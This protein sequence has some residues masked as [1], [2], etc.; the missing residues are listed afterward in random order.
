[1]KRRCRAILLLLIISVAGVNSLPAET[2]PGRPSPG[3]RPAGQGQVTGIPPTER[4][5]HYGP[6][7]RNVLDF[8]QAKSDNPTPV[9]ISIHGGGFRQGDKGIGGWLLKEC[10]DSG[11][12]VAAIT[13]RF[14]QQAI[15]P[16]PFE[17]G[18]LAVQFIRSRA[19]EWNLDPTRVAATGGSAGAGISLWLGFHDDMAD[20]KSDDPIRR[21]STRLT[22]MAVTEGQTSYDPRFI[23]ALFPEKEVFRIPP[24]GQLFGV[25]VNELDHLP[26]E[27][28]KLFEACSPITLL[29]KDDPPALLVYSRPIDAEV[30]ELNVGIHH[31]RFGKA[32]KEKMDELKI[33]CEVDAAGKRLGG[34]TAT[35]VTAFLKEHFGMPLSEADRQPAPPLVVFSAADRQ[36][37]S[38]QFRYWDRDHDGKLSRE[39]VPE[40]LRD[41]FDQVDTNRDGSI[42]PQEDRSFRQ[43]TQGPRS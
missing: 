29:S 30:T 4:D 2:P 37:P 43:R 21:E 42:S 7:E 40:S 8:W 20:Q 1:M 22:C 35:R 25:D 26:A 11:I 36:G 16:A 14:S 17:D 24:V 31:P 15:A 10:L 32:L 23:R 38:E 5:V 9:L 27:K 6:H 34:G 12:S 13:Y 3:Q 41:L 18:A 28:Y 33:P 39:E 19:K